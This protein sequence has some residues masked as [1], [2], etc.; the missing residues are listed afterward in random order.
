M[1][2]QDRPVRLLSTQLL[3]HIGET[4]KTTMKYYCDVCGERRR[5]PITKELKYGLCG[6]CTDSVP[7]HIPKEQEVRFANA[8]YMRRLKNEQTM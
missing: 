8:I 7:A 3:N 2:Q 1:A 4:R 5:W 6:Q